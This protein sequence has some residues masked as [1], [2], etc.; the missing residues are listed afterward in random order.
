MGATARSRTGLALALASAA[1]FGTSGSFATALID[2]GW[3]PA[4]AVT[5]RITVAAVLLTGPALLT[6]RGRWGLLRRRMPTVL[7]YGLVA[8]AG[9]QLFFFNAVQ[10]VPVGLALLLE[11]L[12]IVLIVGWL[13]VR[14]GRRPR[15]L[16]AAGSVAALLGLGLVLDLAGSSHLDPIGVLWG[17]GAAA[18]LAVYFLLSAGTEEPLPAVAMAW[19]GMVVGAATLVALGW[20]GVLPLRATTAAVVVAGYRTS[21]IVP[22]LGLSVI[23]AAFAYIAGIGAARRLGPTLASFVGLTEVLFAVFLAWLLLGQ[24]PGQAQFTGGVCILLGVALVRIDDLRATRTSVFAAEG[25]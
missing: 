7:A 10:R 1:T 18:G 22:V 16:T 11:Y 8:V 19:A 25:S 3:T 15:R 14:H 23:A 4:A 6:M 13:W 20:A 12:G 9:C 17:L 24:L 21:W 2:A 5:V